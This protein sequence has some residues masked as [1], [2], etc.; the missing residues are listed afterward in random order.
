MTTGTN[1][2]RA[3][4]LLSIHRSPL[5][6]VRPHNDCG[7]HGVTRP[8]NVPIP[9]GNWYNPASVLAGRRAVV[10]RPAV[11]VDAHGQVGAD[12]VARIVRAA[13]CR[14]LR[15]ARTPAATAQSGARDTRKK[16]PLFITTASRKIYNRLLPAANNTPN[17]NQPA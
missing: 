3:G 7:A 16:R 14:P 2:G 6:A 1:L 11:S 13:R 4:S 17:R 5:P 9:T 8:T 10:S 12:L 15:Q